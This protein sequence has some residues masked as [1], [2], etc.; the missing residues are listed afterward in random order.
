VKNESH[1]QQGEQKSRVLSREEKLSFIKQRE[2]GEKK[3]PYGWSLRRII[4]PG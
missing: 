2:K 1:R 3:H 4:F